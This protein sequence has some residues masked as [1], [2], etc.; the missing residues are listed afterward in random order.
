MFSLT[1]HPHPFQAM[2]RI[3]EK[4]LDPFEQFVAQSRPFNG[5]TV[6]YQRICN[7]PLEHSKDSL[8]KMKSSNIHNKAYLKP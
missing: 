1:R 6:L 7:L 2:M 3:K 8:Y 4:L 5:K